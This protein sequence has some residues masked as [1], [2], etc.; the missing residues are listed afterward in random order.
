MKYTGR[1]SYFYEEAHGPLN[2]GEINKRLVKHAFEYEWVFRD[3][4]VWKINFRHGVLVDKIVSWVIHASRRRQSE[5]HNKEEKRKVRSNESPTGVITVWQPQE[6]VEIL[7]AH[8]FD[9]R[10]TELFV[11]GVAAMG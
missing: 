9:R 4:I 6:N 11:P 7:L 3:H 5:R 8:L 1:V 10:I 2:L